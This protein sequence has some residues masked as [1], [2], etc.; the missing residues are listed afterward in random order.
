MITYLLVSAV[1]IEAS[2][3]SVHRRAKDV[4]VCEL[5][6]REHQTKF[7]TNHTNNNSELIRLIK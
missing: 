2:G 3:L 7:T 1:V 4:C 6:V 5:S